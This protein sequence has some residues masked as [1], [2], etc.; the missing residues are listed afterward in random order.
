MYA[1]TK[2]KERNKAYKEIITKL[3]KNEKRLYKNPKDLKIKNRRSPTS[4]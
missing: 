4:I 1:V 2:N 3:R